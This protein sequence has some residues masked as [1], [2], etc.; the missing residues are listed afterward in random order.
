MRMTR[1]LLRFLR[2]LDFMYKIKAEVPFVIK[3]FKQSIDFS[4]HATN[5]MKNIFTFL[6]FIADHVVC[7]SEMKIIS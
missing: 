7:F 2:T 1:K 4:M 6:F 5:I 3:S